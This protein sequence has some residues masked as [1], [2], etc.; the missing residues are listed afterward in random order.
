ML[1]KGLLV[2]TLLLCLSASHAQ[3]GDKLRLALEPGFLLFSASKNLGFFVN[4][5]PK[6]KVANNTYLGLRVALV[7]NQQKFENYDPTRYVIDD[8]FD[9]GG[10]SLVPTLDFHFKEMYIRGK[11]FRPYLGFGA[12]I[13]VLSQ[14]VDVISYRP[15][16]KFEVRVDE[17]F[18]ALFR[19]GIEANKLRVGLEY[20]L[21][22]KVDVTIP[23]GP[24]VGTV[25][26]SYLGFYVGL[27]IGPKMV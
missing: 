21:I 15:V 27:L 13:Y 26:N 11:F 3:E 24:T 10:T 7:V 2:Q 23:D 20:N 5:E 12:G 18:G 14:Y 16:D 19:G 9:N 1:R 4:A 17:Q 25:N 22:Q 6:L 8:K